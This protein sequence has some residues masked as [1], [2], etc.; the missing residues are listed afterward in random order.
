MGIFDAEA[1]LLGQ[2]PGLPMFLG[3]LETGIV[4]TT[5][6]LGG[7]ERL[8]ARRR[9]HDQRPVPRRQPH[10]RRRR[11][12]ADLPRRRAG[13]LRR[14]EGALAR[15]RRRRTRGA[16]VDTTEI[17]QEGYRLGPTHLYREGGRCTEVIDLLMR[18]SR[19]PRS[20]WGD[21]HRADHRVPD[22]ASAASSA[23]HERFGSETVAA[24][25]EAIFAPVRAA[26]SRGGRGD[27][28]R[29]LRAEGSMD[30]DGPGG[31][32]V[33][34]AVTVTV[35]GRPRHRRPDR[36]ERP[37]APLGQRAVPGH[38]R[39]RPARLQVPDQP[40]VPVT[41]GTF[42]NLDVVA[43][44]DTVFNAREP[45]AT[46]HYYP[47]LGLAIDLTIKA[48]APALPEAVVAGQPADPMNITIVGRRPD[49]TRW[50]T[51]DATAVGWGAHAGGDGCDGLI[52][53]G[54]GD[55]KNYPIEVIESRYPLRVLAYGLREGSGGAGRYRGGLGIVREYELLERRDRG[56]AL[57]RAL[58]APG[59]GPLRR[60]G[61]HA[62]LAARSSATATIEVVTKANAM[63]LP[64]GSRVR[65]MTGGGGGYGPAERAGRRGSS[66][67]TWRTATCERDVG[68]RRGDRG[69][70]R[71]GRRRAA[72]LHLGLG[73]PR[74]A[75]RRRE[76]NR[77]RAAHT[78][79]RDDAARG[80]ALN[81]ALGYSMVSGAPVG[82][83]GAR[84][85]RP[86][87]RRRG[88]AH[89]AP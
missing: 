37:D 40:D 74:S 65:V 62:D 43:P 32:P 10:E 13:R 63:R 3:N 53:Y 28:R 46:L 88:T 41:A 55:L 23:L 54:A 70:A 73:H 86:A 47:P 15:H 4:A 80:P 38:G 85:R 50:V 60:R 75:G 71:G 20:V 8:P 59:V 31:E 58:E 27:P 82:A 29:R 76:A 11:L 22:R 35:D 21:M 39:G 5:E 51:G 66:P 57:A 48:L 18:N 77:A 12:L 7:P 30:S 34:V 61:R 36:V 87:E 16:P 67:T 14:H 64:R 44:E 49:G 42:R 17:F 25:A 69:R 89:R 68:G 45:H 78:E 83:R 19:L 6:A 81:A 33:H 84:R 52:N 1:R 56:V 26:R 24:A 72:V 2:S 9:L 79:A